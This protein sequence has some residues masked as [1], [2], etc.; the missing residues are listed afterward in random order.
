MK[1]IIAI[2]MILCMLGSMTGCGNDNDNPRGSIHTDTEDNISNDKSSESDTSE[3]TELATDTSTEETTESSTEETPIS[4]GK[5]NGTKYEST[6]I[7]LGFNLPEGWSF[8][9]E[10][11]MLAMNNLS[12]ELLDS[13]QLQ[14]AIENATVICDMYAINYTTGH[15]TNLQLE[16]LNA[17]TNILYDANTYV[18]TAIKS[19]PS[20][21]ETAGYT[22][23]NVKK[24][25][26]TVAGTKHPGIELSCD[27]LGITVF[28]KQACI[29]VGNYMCIITVATSLEDQTDSILSNFYALEE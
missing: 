13:E 17:V 3:N 18:D 19:L 26:V 22:N 4:L 10:D 11:Q 6:F 24:A 28:Q 27:Y 5:S 9:S 16:K 20:T 23:I 25:M 14:A 15:S 12:A 21:L 8:L 1:K 7:G 2:L 29:K